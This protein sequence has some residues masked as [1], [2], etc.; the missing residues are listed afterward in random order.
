MRILF[1]ATPFVPGRAT[2]AGRLVQQAVAHF[3]HLDTYNRFRIFGFAPEVW[4]RSELPE[5]FTYERIKPWPWL[6]PLAQE[7]ARRS[8]IGA[9]LSRYRIDVVHCTLEP[10]PIYDE[11]ARVLFS[12]YDLARRSPHFRAAAPQRLRTMARTFL[13]YRLAAKADLIHTI[14][15]YSADR[16]AETLGIARHKIRVVYPGVDPIFT[17]GPADAAVLARHGLA[18]APYFLFVGQLGRQK[19]ED[20]LIA[21]F[22]RAVRE[23][24]I[25]DA[26]LALVGDLSACRATTRRLVATE[27]PARVHLLPGVTDAE[28]VHLY[29]GA[30]ALVLPSFDEGFGLPAVE[31]MACGTPAIVSNVTSLPEVVDVAGLVVA[32][33]NIDELADALARLAGDAP[34]RDTMSQKALERAERFTFSAYA[35]GLLRLYK[36]LANG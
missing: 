22:N 7:A 21:A 31:A 29:R 5:N 34:W 35:S 4:P 25:G 11:H 30:I 13:R 20:G 36:E 28:L 6:G 14:S 27:A 19:N 26:H 16:I 23:H 3:F 33:S 24:T 2:G 12:L 10:T 8:H 9:M 1:D 17:A 32:P 15:H 18:D